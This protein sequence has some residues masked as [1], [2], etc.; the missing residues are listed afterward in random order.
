MSI[1]YLQ[2]IRDEL[3][4]TWPDNR[5]INLVFHG[6]SVP[7]GYFDTPDVRIAEAYPRLVQ[8][9]LKERDQYAVINAIITAIGGEHSAA[10][11]ERFADVLAHRPDV[12]LIDYALND[13][14]IGLEP[15]R[16]SWTSM[17]T[18]A[19]EAG[20]KIILL[21]PSGDLRSDLTDPTDDLARHAEQVRELAARHNLPLADTAA[22]FV[23]AVVAGTDLAD[24]MSH[25]NH[26]NERGHRLIAD[27]V[28]R[29]F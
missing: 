24:L 19:V 12:L 25:V 18:R 6:H 4:R 5:T 8:D 22:A 29:L 13:R 1:D 2:P 16:Q 21:T 14:S 20:I 3:T 10:G 15:A 28:L 9:G 26:P 27:A 11:A 7:A 23:D 17:I